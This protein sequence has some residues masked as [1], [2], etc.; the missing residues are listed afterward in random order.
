M[1]NVTG[2]SALIETD[3]KQAQVTTALSVEYLVPAPANSF[4]PQVDDPDVGQ[5]GSHHEASQP[6][7]I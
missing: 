4:L 7:G 1:S 2:S 3:L 6:V 5:T